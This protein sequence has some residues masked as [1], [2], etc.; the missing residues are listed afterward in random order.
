MKPP[1]ASIDVAEDGRPVIVVDS[2]T[3]DGAH[4]RAS[5][6]AAVFEA[7]LIIR[8]YSGNG[9]LLATTFTT[10]TT[11]AP[12]RGTW[13]FRLDLP[14]D[15]ALVRLGEELQETELE[16][17]TSIARGVEIEVRPES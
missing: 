4:L 7:N 3:I 9:T 15:T 13:S 1:L 11:G 16:S 12:G 8:A 14:R 2:V 10:A 5:G 6:S 17:E